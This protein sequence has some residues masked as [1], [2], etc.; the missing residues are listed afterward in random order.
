[1][2]RGEPDPSCSCVGFPPASLL[3]DQAI[4]ARPRLLTSTEMPLSI[5]RFVTARLMQ[6]RS[7]WP[8]VSMAGRRC[9]RG[10]VLR[11][12]PKNSV[13]NSPWS[14]KGRLRGDSPRPVGA[15]IDYGFRSTHT[16]GEAEIEVW[17]ADRENDYHTMVAIDGIID[18]RSHRS[19]RAGEP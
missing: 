13:M 8:G 11:H 6:R 14:G 2:V 19:G 12:N 3:H 5:G 10:S 9:R 1:M 7:F 18:V 16:V 17:E 4:L 15:T